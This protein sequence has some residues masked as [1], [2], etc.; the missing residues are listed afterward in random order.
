M[1]PTLPPP[2]RGGSGS[3]I[4]CPFNPADSVGVKH[5]LLAG[6]GCVVS[7]PVAPKGLGENCVARNQP[8][9]GQGNHQSFPIKTPPVGGSSLRIWR[10]S[11][12]VGGC[13]PAS[14]CRVSR[15]RCCR[16]TGG[17]VGTPRPRAPVADRLSNR[18]QF[19]GD[20]IPTP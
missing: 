6:Y 13:C 7:P 14:Y 11:S 8:K 3:P 10:N 2:Y 12:P 4:Y 18:G 5:R 1:G 16:F 19:F 9:A 20:Q 17:S 15:R